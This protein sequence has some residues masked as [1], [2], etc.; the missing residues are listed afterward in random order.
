MWVE[1][2]GKL[3]PSYLEQRRRAWYAVLDVPV[4]LR[5]A[6]GKKRLVQSLKTDSQR[7]AERRIGAVISRWKT[8][9]E[10]LRR[11]D[12][13][14]RR[15]HE[16]R[17]AA[18]R[19]RAAIADPDDVDPI[20]DTDAI[21]R[22]YERLEREQGR[23]AAERFLRIFKAEGELIEPHFDRWVS[24]SRYAA[25]T[26]L[27]VQQVRALLLQRHA[28]VGE[29]GRREAAAFVAEVLVPGRR[30]ASVNK[31]LSHLSSFW[32]WLRKRGVTDAENPWRDQRVP[33]GARS[34]EPEERRTPMPEREGAAL[35]AAVDAK[36]SKHPADPVVL[37]LVASTGMRL[38][39]ACGLT[40]KDLEVRNKVLFVYVREGKT[41]AAVRWVPVLLP[42][43]TSALRQRAQAGGPLF[44]ELNADKRGDRSPRIS[45]RL[46]RAL[47]TITK[48]S[49]IVAAHS[50]RHRAATLMEQADVPATTAARLLG[51]ERQGET[52]GRYSKGP[53][54]AQLIAAA[55]P[56]VLPVA[57]AR[58][59]ARAS[60]RV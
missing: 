4:E 9:L 50:W 13:V 34:G 32:R 20:A 48:D 5:S 15:A 33:E 40:A 29:V 41:P 7:V 31:M 35:I 42:E 19:F 44:P 1:R 2:V 26:L 56:I 45:Q 25:K 8:E 54:D 14:A 46:G 37:R 24:E 30:P 3:V 38:E 51:H 36:A 28:T 57:D 58:R 59:S 53:S 22:E 12:P 11:A 27:G 17:T 16:L 43:V 47:R 6:V 39:E 10:A 21:E 49:S 60:R 23:S 52:L 55:R 18:E